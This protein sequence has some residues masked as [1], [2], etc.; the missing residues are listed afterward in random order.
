MPQISTESLSVTIADLGAEM[1]GLSYQGQELLW[2]GDPAWWSGQAPILFP[3]VGLPAADGVTIDGTPHAISKHGFA[4]R[5]PFRVTELTQSRCCHLLEPSQETAAYPFDFRL[6]IV[7]EVVG[8][9]LSV[10]ATVSNAGDREMPFSFGFHPAFRWPLP[11]ATGPHRIELRNGAEPALARLADGML[12]RARMPSP[13]TAGALTLDPAQYEDD[14]MIFPEGAG[15]GLRYRADGAPVLDFRFSNLPNLA[16]WQKPGAPYI[17]IEP[18]HGLPAAE[19]AGP[20]LAA[21]PDSMILAPGGQETF[22]MTL[23]VSG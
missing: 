5:L 13:F 19:G 17:C 6:E 21:R 23:Q 20:E 10:T 2:E 12:G 8:A 11:G 18:W 1:Q 22:A 4:R 3:I 15:D 16:L 9:E 7:H 14:A